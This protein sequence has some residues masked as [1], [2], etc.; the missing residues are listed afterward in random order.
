MI[1]GIRMGNTLCAIS[2]SDTRANRQVD[3]LLQSVGIKRDGNLD[4]TCGIFDD[5][6]RLIATGSCFHNT[7]RCLAVAAD[8]QSPGLTLT[9]L[10]LIKLCKLDR[11]RMPYALGIADHRDVCRPAVT[12]H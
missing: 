6:W 10:E 3:A 4:Y 11:I 1:G 2:A 12:V 8:V 5:D 9:D 7:I